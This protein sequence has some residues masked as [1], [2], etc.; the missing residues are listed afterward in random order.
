M[1]ESNFKGNAFNIVWT[2]DENVVLNKLYD[3]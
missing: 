2:E 3:A 1:L